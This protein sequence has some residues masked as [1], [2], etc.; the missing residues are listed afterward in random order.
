MLEAINSGGLYDKIFLIFAS[1]SDIS[2]THRSA[3]DGKAMILHMGCM[4]EPLCYEASYLHAIG[5]KAIKCV[6][7]RLQRIFLGLT[8]RQ[9]FK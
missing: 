1:S 6:C 7:V 5:R 8:V 4:Y 2:S 3:D 9:F